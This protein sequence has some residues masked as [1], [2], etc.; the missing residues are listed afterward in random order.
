MFNNQQER[1][2]QIQLFFEINYPTFTLQSSGR[3][4]SIIIQRFIKIYTYLVHTENI[5]E[6]KTAHICPES[7]FGHFEIP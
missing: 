5:T 7:N 3:F 6:W 4:Q 2:I 1:E